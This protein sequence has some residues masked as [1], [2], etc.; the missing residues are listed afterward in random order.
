MISKHFLEIIISNLKGETTET[1]VADFNT[2]F[3]TMDISYSQEIN[4]K[5][6]ELN[7]TLDQDLDIYRTVPHTAAD[8]HSSSAH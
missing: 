4:K 8:R 5:T 7:Y 3:S 6:L 1:I 2:L